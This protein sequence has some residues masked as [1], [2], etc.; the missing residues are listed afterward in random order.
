MQDRVLH[1]LRELRLE[2]VALR[3]VGAAAESAAA[4][5][6]SSRLGGGDSHCGSGHLS[7]VLSKLTCGMLG[8]GGG[9]EA[10]GLS[11]GEKRRVS[12]GME[13]VT[14][15]LVIIMDEPTSGLDSYSALALLRACK[16]VRGGLAASEWHG[17]SGDESD[18]VCVLEPL[19][20]QI[21]AGTPSHP[22]LQQL[23]FPSSLQPDTPS[24]LRCISAH[25]LYQPNHLEMLDS[26][27]AQ[28]TCHLVRR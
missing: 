3:Q 17:L 25:H 19:F 5:G 26:A 20:C 18:A 1:V 23:N 11:G 4:T 24:T 8:G 10:R 27:L 7:H 13:L 14:E 9:G 2:H 21:E 12:I 22:C 28:S 15:P 6:T 16:E